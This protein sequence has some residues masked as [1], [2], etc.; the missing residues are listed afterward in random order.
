MFHESILTYLQNIR[1]GDKLKTQ[2]S[3]ARKRREKLIK[4][5][6]TKHML[7]HSIFLS[8]GRNGL[9]VMHRALGLG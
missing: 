7:P 8:M 9:T 4:Q 2:V 1:C 6:N 5:E 3:L